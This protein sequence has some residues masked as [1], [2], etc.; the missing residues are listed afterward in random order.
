ML[1]FFASLALLVARPIL[2]TDGLL[3]GTVYE[4]GSGQRLAGANVQV[5]GTVLGAVCDRQGRFAVGRVPE[6]VQRLRVTMIGYREAILD[7]RVPADESVRVVLEPAAIAL[8]PVVVTAEQR[9]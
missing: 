5:L 1:Y 4:A 6:G 9:P 8:D 7:I 3:E 2:A